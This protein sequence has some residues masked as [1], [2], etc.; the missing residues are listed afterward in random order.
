MTVFAL[1]AAIPF[2]LGMLVWVPVAIT[3]GYAA[4]RHI[5]TEGGAVVPA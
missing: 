5:Y 1:L 4:Y 2:A 3:S